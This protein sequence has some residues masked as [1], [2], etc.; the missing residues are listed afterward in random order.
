MACV[1]SLYRSGNF[2]GPGCCYV[3]G[4]PMP[5]DVNTLLNLLEEADER[6]LNEVFQ[7]RS[8]DCKGRLNPQDLSRM[9]AK[10]KAEHPIGYVRASNLIYIASAPNLA[11]PVP[12]YGSALENVR[13]LVIGEFYDSATTY[14]AAQVLS[15]PARP[16]RTRAARAT[17]A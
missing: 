5:V 8:V 6:V 3:P 11:R 14:T 2:D 7:V 10:L 9:W 15:P 12:T 16:A 13:P 4:D 17:T 1:E